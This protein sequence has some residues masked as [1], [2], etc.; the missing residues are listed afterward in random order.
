[1]DGIEIFLWFACEQKCSFCFQKDLRYENPKFLD[2]SLVFD[3][4]KK[5]YRNKKT[6]IIFSWGEATLDKNLLDYI[7]YSKKI[8]F[9]DI[10][11]HTNGLKFADNESLL[12]FYNTGMTW[13]IISIH[14]YG[15]IHDILVWYDS[16]FEKVKKTLVNITKIIQNNNNFTLDTNTVLTRTNYNSLHLLTKF[17]AYFPINRSQIVQLYSLYLFSWNEKKKLYITYKEFE[18][19][20]SKIFP[21]KLNITF[22]NFPL[23]KL[24]KA[25]WDSVLTRKKYNNDAYGNIG[26]WLEDSDCTFIES[27]SICKKRDSCT[28]IPKDYLENYPHEKFY[29]FT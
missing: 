27:C 14:W 8:W 12:K 9:N 22:E 16:A 13:V 3:L 18:P 20:L 2:S 5:W 23:C 7:A 4:I 10:R 29:P 17:L 11:V 28:W 26:E 25:Y 6:S 1:M 19:Y 15:K 24:D 21:S